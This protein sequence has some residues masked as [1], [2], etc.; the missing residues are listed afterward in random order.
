VRFF[1]F[2]TLATH[3]VNDPNAETTLLLHAS[4][5]QHLVPVIIVARVLNDASHRNLKRLP[6]LRAKLPHALLKINA[7]HDLHGGNLPDS[8][9][10]YHPLSSDEHGRLEVTVSEY[11]ED[12]YEAAYDDFVDSL[13][14]Q[15]REE[16]REEALEDEV[17]YANVVEDF[18]S[19][20]LKSYY[21]ANPD[22]LLPSHRTFIY[23]Q[24]LLA[25]YPTAA[26]VFAA[27]ASEVCLVNALLKPIVHG[28]VH[29]DTTAGLIVDL[30]GASGTDR[31]MKGLLR[32]LAV[33]G[34]IDLATY[35]ITGS[36]ASLRDAFRTTRERRNAILHRG[37]EGTKEDAEKALSVAQTM[38]ERVF[39]KV[40]EALG[41]HMHQDNRVCDAYK[42]PKAMP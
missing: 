7:K 6:C 4:A 42:C 31:L 39:P 13:R 8:P 12:A 40:M 26:L 22:V 5:P 41:L 28:L 19:E 17:L 1:G 21:V 29:A 36:G 23:A 11:G 24:M 27:S 20:R 25:Q 18:A 15:F 2:S 30:V 37:E 35:S 34:G 32:V 14:N 3:A 10:Q 16:F 9:S 38:V 33:H